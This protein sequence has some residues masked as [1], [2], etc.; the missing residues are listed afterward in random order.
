MEEETWK[1]LALKPAGWNPMT[2]TTTKNMDI[3]ETG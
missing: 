3:K 2:K 1:D